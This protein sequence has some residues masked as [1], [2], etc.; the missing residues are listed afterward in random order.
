[1]S[2][3]FLLMEATQAPA[4]CV[5]VCVLRGLEDYAKTDMLVGWP[6]DLADSD[7]QTDA[8]FN[9]EPAC[10]MLGSA[11]SQCLRRETDDG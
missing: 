5:G 8:Q 6:A 1:M 11:L 4:D 10:H 2:G 9:R 7:R 3:P